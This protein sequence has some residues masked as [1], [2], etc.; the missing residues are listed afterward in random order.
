MVRK[1]A[2]LVLILL[3]NIVLLVYA[4]VPHHHHHEQICIENSH[5]QDDESTHKHSTP[6][7]NHEHDG[8]GGV[9]NCVFKQT[10]AIPVNSFRQDLP[11]FEGDDKNAPF[12]DY[13]AHIANKDLVSFV[14]KIIS[15]AHRS[16]QTFRL[17]N[18]FSASS[19]LRAPP[20]V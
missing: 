19:G 10:L 11:F 1:K 20:T 12:W 6:E 14:P 16:P 5:C 17:S 18:F 3:A 4:V 15:R 7:H 9:D 13:T 8:S 2:A